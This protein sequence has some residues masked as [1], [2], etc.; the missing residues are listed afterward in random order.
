MTAR[1]T[2]TE[3]VRVGVRDGILRVTLDRPDVRNALSLGALQQLRQIFV[4]HAED[5]R[6]RVAIL[7]STGDKAFASG[8][9]LK[10]LQSVRSSR[11]AAS[12]SEH[13]KSALNAVRDF[14]V[15]VVAGLQ[16]VALGGGAELALAC[17]HR[18]AAANAAIGF[19][20]CR[21]A[22][23]PS[24]GGGVDLMRLVG[25]SRGMRLLLS[26]EILSSR[27]ACE[28]GLYDAVVPEGGDFESGLEEFVRRMHGHPPQVMRAIKSLAMGERNLDRPALQAAETAHF[29]EVWIH[30]DHWAA[31]DR[32]MR[33][34][35]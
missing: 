27:E 35:S 20:H 34:R 23:A 22:I 12:L 24:W 21:L 7:T 2:P 1:I 5:T 32:A 15:P 18:F 6:L 31:V 17:D 14:P 13:G 33:S 29:S 19:I 25:P 30:V 28:I 9:D 8:G 16:G 4:E 3:D 26:G 10:E 11:D